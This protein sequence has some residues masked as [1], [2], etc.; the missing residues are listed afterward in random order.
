[1]HHALCHHDA[2]K[3]PWGVTQQCCIPSLCQLSI[4]KHYMT[5]NYIFSQAVWVRR[6]WKGQQCLCGWPCAGWT[7]RLLHLMCHTVCRGCI[8]LCVQIHPGRQDVHHVQP[9]E[10][11]EGSWQPCWVVPGECI[12]HETTLP[13]Q[14]YLPNITISCGTFCCRLYMNSLWPREWIPIG[15]TADWSL[16]PT[17]TP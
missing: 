9:W 16:P 11:H 2:W 12:E 8:L 7:D 1:M 17:P 13:E 4:T 6:S 14:R 5:L 15:L 10:C 3:Q